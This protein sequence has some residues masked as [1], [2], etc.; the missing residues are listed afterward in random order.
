MNPGEEA[1]PDSRQRNDSRHGTSVTPEDH[2]LNML[3]RFQ[4]AADAAADAWDADLTMRQGLDIVWMLGNVIR[5]FRVFTVMLSR[6]Q[7]TGPPGGQPDLSAPNELISEASQCLNAA[8]VLARIG[9]PAIHAGIKANLT[10]DVPAGGDPAHDGP[11]VAAVHAMQNALRVF[12]DIWREPSGTAEIRNQIVMETMFAMASMHIAVSTLAEKAPKP[13]DT[14]LTLIA[15]NFDI[16]CGHLRESLICSATGNY[17]HGTEDLA[18]QIRAAYP[19]FSEIGEAALPA[20]GVS[21]TA[22]PG[23][24]ATCF[25]PQPAT[26]PST[27]THSSPGPATASRRPANGLAH[28]EGLHE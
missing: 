6:Y 17:Q 21:G 13:F 15:R 2:M 5:E 8:R 11:A 24:A 20:A 14:T 28:P 3:Q 4:D 9:Q 16:S 18:H 12:D 22:A 7:V 23:L 1:E 10:R 19:L 25:P 26:P 27:P